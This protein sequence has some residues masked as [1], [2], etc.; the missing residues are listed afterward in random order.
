MEA[1]ETKILKYVHISVKIKTNLNL[2]S[3]FKRQH[4]QVH[5]TAFIIMD[6]P[7]IIDL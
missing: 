6:Y 4:I 7:C 5:V 3:A 1:Q 2:Q